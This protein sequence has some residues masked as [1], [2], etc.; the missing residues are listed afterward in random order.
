[1]IDEI[2]FTALKCNMLFHKESI[3]PIGWTYSSVLPWRLKV[4]RS[5][6]KKGERHMRVREHL[7]WFCIFISMIW[8]LSGLFVL[9]LMLCCK[10][11]FKFCC[12]FF[13]T[14]FCLRWA[15]TCTNFVLW[16]CVLLYHLFT[17][18]H[19]SDMVFLSFTQ[20]ILLK[21]QC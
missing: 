7:I 12:C 1:M 20:L 11:T 5:Y 13:G 14:F 4:I 2:G 16:W 18:F 17:W 3:L 10:I 21:S 8:I 19:S 15:S 6:R 9:V